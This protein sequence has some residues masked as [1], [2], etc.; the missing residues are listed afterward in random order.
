MRTLTWGN[1]LGY[2]GGLNPIAQ[3]L[4]VEKALL[5]RAGGEAGRRG[6]EKRAGWL[7]S[8]SKGATAKVCRPPWKLGTAPLEPPE[9]TGA[10]RT[11]GL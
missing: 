5:V 2:P 3:I 9:G 1:G 6:G 11:V 8:R 7:C 4:K 10:L